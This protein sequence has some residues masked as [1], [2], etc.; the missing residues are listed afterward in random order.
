[1]VGIMASAVV[2]LIASAVGLALMLQFVPAAVAGT[3]AGI[4]TVITVIVAALSSVFVVHLD[5][6]IQLTSDNEYD[7]CFDENTEI[8]L[9]YN[10]TKKISEIQP[11]DILDNGSIVTSVM[12]IERNHIEMYKYNNVIVSKNHRIIVGP[13]TFIPVYKCANALKVNN[14]DKKYIYCFN[15]N[16]KFIKINKT[17]FVDW[18][19]LDNNELERIFNR[20]NYTIQDNIFGN[21]PV[22]NI[23]H[24][25]KSTI[26]EYLDNGFH[27][28]TLITLSDNRQL[29]ISQIEPGMI[30]KGNNKIF[31]V[32]VIKSNHIPL[33]RIENKEKKIDIILSNNKIKF[34][35]LYENIYTVTKIKK[36]ENTIYHLVTNS[37]KI[38][39][40]NIVFNHY[41]Y[42]IEKF[43]N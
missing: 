29:P 41:N 14:Y 43:L 23:N 19:D 33:I 21:N 1:M 35:E 32:I 24:I 27:K 18:D 34:D 40:G 7:G 42:C 12:K 6:L 30:T 26:A 20:L 28:D 38:D 16:V 4:V 10:K 5:E 37:K 11:F 22:I 8:K 36:R 39:I 13:N 9:K 3:T 25:P 15:T 2:A 17:I 31:G